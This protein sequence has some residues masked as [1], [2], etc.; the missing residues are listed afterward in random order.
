LY[1]DK[2]GT[3]SI[4]VPDV[5]RVHF[6]NL[7][8]DVIAQEYALTH[9][10]KVRRKNVMVRHPKH[11][12]MIANIDRV[13]EGQRRGVECKNVDL[14]AWRFGEWGPAG[15]DQVPLPF[16]LQV[17]HYMC[18]LDYPEWDLAALVGGNTLR[19]YHFVRDAELEQLMI[20]S[21]AE[22][23]QHVERREPPPINF[24]HPGTLRLVKALHPGTNGKTVTLDTAMTEWH[25]VKQSLEENIKRDTAA[26][27]ACKARLLDAMGDNAIGLLSDGGGEYRR[28]V[29]T[30]SA[31]QVSETSYVDFRFSSR[32]SKGGSK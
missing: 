7:L 1:H 16:V 13:I 24:A 20:E 15:T 8:E 21:E 32:L 14:L 22:F 2:I 18:V 10:V 12:Y 6:G 31:Y 17:A 29:V 23:W 4:D 30:R 25:T 5:G 3:A 11:Q 26:L 9:H 28:K 27:D 19:T